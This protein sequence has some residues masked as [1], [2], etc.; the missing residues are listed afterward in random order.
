MRSD[1][2]AL[3]QTASPPARDRSGAAGAKGGRLRRAFQGAGKLE[4]AQ[5]AA[6]PGQT[7]CAAQ[8]VKRGAPHRGSTR[9]AYQLVKA[10]HLSNEL[11][12]VTIA[13]VMTSYTHEW[14]KC[15]F[16]GRGGG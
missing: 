12:L 9:I 1:A 10:R 7:T 6:G 2:P 11:K 4:S 13:W 5:E 16:G 8:D 15:G 14:R 3:P